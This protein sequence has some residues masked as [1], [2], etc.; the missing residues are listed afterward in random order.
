M[1]NYFH[2]INLNKKLNKIT[3]YFHNTFLLLLIPILFISFSLFLHF[4]NKSYWFDEAYTVYI[5]GNWKLLIDAISRDFNMW[6][7]YIILFL[8][9]NLFGNT[10]IVNRSLSIIFFI[11]TIISC[12][13]LALKIFNKNTAII[14]AFFITVNPILIE[15]SQ[16]TRSYSMALFFLCLSNLYFLNYLDQ[17]QKYS[18]LFKYIILII[19]GAYTHIFTLLILPFHITILIIQRSF[20]SV[21]FILVSLI[22]AI[23]PILW[24]MKSV[25]LTTTFWAT[26]PSISGTIDMLITLLGGN[27]LLVISLLLM[28]YAMINLKRNYKHIYLVFWIISFFLINIVYSFIHP[29]IFVPRYLIFTIPPM[30]IIAS[31]GLNLIKNTA[32]K[33]VI[34][35]IAIMLSLL[36]I[37]NFQYLSPK[38]QWREVAEKICSDKE[39]NIRV[40]PYAYFVD[41]PL[42]HYLS[43]CSYNLNNVINLS[44]R[45]YFAGGGGI[46]PEPD[47][48]KIQNSISENQ[49]IYLVLSHYDSREMKRY[50]Q[51]QKIK[52]YLASR[53]IESQIFKYSSIDLYL[54]K[55]I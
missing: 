36:S 18:T 39:Q 14:S 32:I 28:I 11:F 31:F 17:N 23:S 44:S 55:K 51:A 19:I 49:K 10:E 43:Q 24:V 35:S 34:F 9:Q 4:G 42:K 3:N 40:I 47:F 41:I 20:K 2:R 54:Y 16:E 37:F 38:E 21:S 46:L 33:I 45:P 48:N 13:K 26:I 6:F 15:Y 52:N 30:I 1:V 27:Y 53:Y 50:D 8:Y 22:V 5:T 29:S 12:Y 25:K 7:Y